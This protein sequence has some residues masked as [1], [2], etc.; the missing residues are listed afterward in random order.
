MSGWR[1]RQIADKIDIDMIEFKFY[2]DAWVYCMKNNIPIKSITRD[3][4]VWR[5]PSGFD[6]TEV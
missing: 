4:D 2:L 3:R 1:K 5:T 6:T